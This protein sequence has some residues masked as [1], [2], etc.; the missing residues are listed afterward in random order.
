M[1]RSVLRITLVAGEFMA[2]KRKVTLIEDNEDC[3]GILATMIL[4]TGYQVILTDGDVA[5]ET[6]DVT[7]V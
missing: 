3:R 2:Q 1:A 4:L 7:V 5:Y 6:T